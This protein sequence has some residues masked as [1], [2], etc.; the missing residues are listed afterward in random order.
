[1]KVMVYDFQG[2]V[3]KRTAASAQL[4][5]S[6]QRK[7]SHHA[8]MA[9]AAPQRGHMRELVQVKPSDGCKPS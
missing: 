5:L 6:F 4:S 1:M 3:T 2:P 9:Q 8:E 7:A